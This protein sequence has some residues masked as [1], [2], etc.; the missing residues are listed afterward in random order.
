MLL[1]AKTDGRFQGLL[2]LI[3]SKPLTDKPGEGTP[4]SVTPLQRHG[5]SSRICAPAS[6][7]LGTLA[8]TTQSASG[9][10]PTLAQRYC[11]KRTHLGCRR[12]SNSKRL[13]CSRHAPPVTIPRAGAF[14]DR[15]RKAVLIEGG[16]TRCGYDAPVFDPNPRSSPDS[17]AAVLLHLFRFTILTRGRSGWLVDSYSRAQ[18]RW[19]GSS[20]ECAVRHRDGA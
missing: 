8:R 20:R 15:A 17:R 3:V 4:P 11:G 19:V 9:S 12:K 18:G 1:L 13:I 5:S 16:A 6:M 2:N 7:R 14:H 10:Q